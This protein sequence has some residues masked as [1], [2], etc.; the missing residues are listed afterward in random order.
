MVLCAVL[1]ATGLPADAARVK[2]IA[3]IYGVRD[4]NLLGY[5]LVTGC[6]ELVIPCGIKPHPNSGKTSAGTW[7][8]FDTRSIRRETLPSSW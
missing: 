3:D 4:N 5:G 2:D 6:R 8:N 1:L 7:C